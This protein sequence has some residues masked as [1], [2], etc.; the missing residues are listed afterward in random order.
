MKSTYTLFSDPGHAWLKVP[1]SEIHLLA[2][3]YEISVCSYVY[4]DFVYLEEDCDMLRFITAWKNH[5]Q[6]NH[7]PIFKARYS[8]K[9]SRIRSYDR[10]N[11][12]IET[13]EE[14]QQ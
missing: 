13:K 7:S 12:Y 8:N 5:K 9:Y 11:P 10:Y 1:L 2:L 4:G 6:V 14:N 3:T